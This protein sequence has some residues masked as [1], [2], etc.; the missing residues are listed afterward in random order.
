MCYLYV[1]CG[2][3][4]VFFSIPCSLPYWDL[5]TEKLELIVEKCKNQINTCLLSKQ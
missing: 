2:D 1:S 3:L 5:E 4:V